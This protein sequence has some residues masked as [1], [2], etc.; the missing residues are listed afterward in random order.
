MRELS[1]RKYLNQF[2]DIKVSRLIPLLQYDQNWGLPDKYKIEEYTTQINVRKR[3]IKVN[4][5]RLLGRISKN[6]EKPITKKIYGG[7]IRRQGLAFCYRNKELWA[8]LKSN[9]P[10]TNKNL[11]L[12]CLIKNNWIFFIVPKNYIGVWYKY[13]RGRINFVIIPEKIQLRREFWETFGIL[14]GEMM[15]KGRRIS[16][17]N[18]SPRVINCILNYFDKSNLI[19][20]DDWTVTININGRN[21]CDNKLVYEKKIKDYWSS[22][23]LYCNI[24][25]VRWCNYNSTLN[26]NFG[27]INLDYNNKSLTKIIFYLIKFIRENVLRNKQDSMDFLRGLIAAEGSVDKDKR[28]ILQ[29]V[30]IASKLKEEREFY[31]ALLQKINIKSKIYEGNHNIR[32][33]G[34]QNFILFLEYKLFDLHEKRYQNF[35]QRFSNLLYIRASLLLF[36]KSLTVPEI[37]RLLDPNDYRNLNKNFSKLTKLGYLQRVKTSNGFKYSLSSKFKWLLQ[38][39]RTPR[40]TS[41]ATMFP[42]PM[43]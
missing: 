19:K 4:R 41:L 26:P 2:E 25:A 23:L 22:V 34:F 17:S 16:V 33:G 14:F 37:V 36:N 30:K 40:G 42:M 24:K 31:H 9:W 18:T 8:V 32:S 15:R 29:D 43:P 20:L 21:I 11:D 6:C 13:G 3:F 5:L 35:I 27:Q 38:P 12:K 39:L 10:I 1:L 7:D 28:N